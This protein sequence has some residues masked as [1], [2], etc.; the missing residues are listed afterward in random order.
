M[1][2]AGLS[3]PKDGVGFL[4]YE[5]SEG[6]DLN[7]KPAGTCFFVL[8]DTGSRKSHYIVTA[9]HVLDEMRDGD[10]ETFVRVNRQGSGVLSIPLD[11]SAWVLH[12]E[13]DLAVYD[14]FPD[15][16]AADPKAIV[17]IA[18]LTLDLISSVEQQAKKIK[19]GWPPEETEQVFFI[20]LMLSYQGDGRNYPVVRM[21]HVA[22]NTDEPIDLESGLSRYR[23]I[24]SQCY[25][26]NS[27]APVWA[28]LEN[29]RGGYK[30]IFLGVLTLGFQSEPETVGIVKIVN[31]GISAVVPGEYLAEMIM[32]LE[33]EKDQQPKSGDRGTTG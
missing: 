33:K 19:K 22:L 26:G 8:Q 30:S 11:D 24:E 10:G 14:G 27:G 28:Y 20:G 2:P 7:K 17:E 32:D 23:I 18:A 15:V 5:K 21:G 6:F 25:P 3:K 31:Y 4:Y 9:K 29:R 12:P 16:A 1:I 13:V